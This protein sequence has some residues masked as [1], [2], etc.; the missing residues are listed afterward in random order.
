MKLPDYRH[1]C[2]ETDSNSLKAQQ[3]YDQTFFLFEATAS[4]IRREFYDTRLAREPVIMTCAVNTQRP[5]WT[6]QS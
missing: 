1:G 3:V 4:S 2:R 5:N 6:M